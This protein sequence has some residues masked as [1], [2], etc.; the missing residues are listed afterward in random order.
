MT[1]I[2][3]A[4]WEIM[5]VIWAKGSVT[6]SY[7]INVLAPMNWS[8]STIKTLLSRLVEKGIVAAERKGRSYHYV[9]LMTEQE[10][11]QAEVL[12]V[13]KRICQTE[14]AS[15]LKQLLKETPMT[16]A[17]VEQLQE[18]LAEK[19]PVDEVGCHCLPGQ[20]RCVKYLEVTHG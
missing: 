12:S 3:I 16:S 19:K 5:R 15:L 9:A 10:A 2:T 4:E 7:I 14:H 1:D 11:Y 13:F 8:D 20:C 17:D 6:S 18:L